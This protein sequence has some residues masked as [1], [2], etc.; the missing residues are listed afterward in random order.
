MSI[1]HDEIHW[2]P[3]SSH[4]VLLSTP[5]G[6]NR[7]QNLR[8]QGSPSPSPTKRLKLSADP[9]DAPDSNVEDLD[10][11][12]E[13]ILQ[14]Q[15]Q[16]IQARLRLKKLRKKKTLNSGTGLQNLASESVSHLEKSRS[17]ISVFSQSFREEERDESQS[18]KPQIA[19]DVPASPIRRKA[20]SPDAQRSPGRVL[21]GIDKGLKG[22]D[23]SLKRVP[24]FRNK[25]TVPN[26]R[27]AG[28]FSQRSEVQS[29]DD[30]STSSNPRQKSFN[31]RLAAVRQQDIEF[32]RRQSRL[33]KSRSTA[34]EIDRSQM[35]KL[36]ESAVEFPDLPRQAPEFSRDEVLSSLSEPKGIPS[37]NKI[38][39]DSFS[40]G[41]GSSRRPPECPEYSSDVTHRKN[42]VPPP[43]PLP[44]DK[45]TESEASQ[46]EPYS[47]QHLTKRIIPH[48]QLTR[49]LAEKKAYH[50][51]DLLR[52][53]KPP[54]FAAPDVEEDLVVLGII[55]SKSEPK[56][57]QQTAKNSKRQKYMVMTLTD[58]KWEVDLFLFDSAFEKFWKMTPG[59]I[60]AILNPLFMPPPRGKSDASK[61]SLTLNSDADTILEIGTARDLGFCKSVKRDGKSCNAWIDK[62][63]TEFCAYHVNASL[64]KTRASRMEV[65]TM[66]FGKPKYATTGRRHDPTQHYDRESHSKIF[67]G[68]RPTATLLDDVDVDPDHFHRGSTKEERLT[69]RLLAQERERLLEHKLARLG[70]SLASD[71]AR[72]RLAGARPSAAAASTALEPPPSRAAKLG[73]CD[74][75]LKDVALSPIKRKRTDTLSGTTA[76]GW[77]AQLLNDLSKQDKDRDRPSLAPA[78]KKTRF[79]TE[80]GIREAGRESLSTEITMPITFDDS[81]DDLDIV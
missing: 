54:D 66:T 3:R 13:E 50:I 2:P 56:T 38:S 46:F 9:N 26:S 45:T 4:E 23:I 53:V 58:L 77:G 74:K 25:E 24:S 70:S 18:L 78:K 64:Q 52:E 12:D 67:I 35:Q 19:V 79:V 8:D 28:P 47:S 17:K 20:Q 60:I 31:E 65:N 11:D 49:A 57:H 62:R 69:R 22:R 80:K 33:K 34:F 72:V 5:G 27:L 76:R 59:T 81:D 30:P 43:L 71:Y 29:G 16:E 61:F 42:K 55:A 37:R 63:H 68:R 51:P 39:S 7:L 73:L 10:N 75:G 21:L 14:L 15:L 36:K 41:G 32:Q 40:A 44:G 48:Q 1:Y 6:R